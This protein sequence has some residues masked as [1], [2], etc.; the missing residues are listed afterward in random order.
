MSE[1]PC[2]RACIAPR[3][4]VFTEG[5]GR[6]CTEDCPGCLPRKAEYG[7]L[8][9]ACHKRLDQSLRDAPGQVAILL[10]DLAP[11]YARQLTAETMA[12]VGAHSMSAGDTWPSGLYAKASASPQEGEALRLAHLDLAQELADWISTLVER[13]CEDH[14]MTGPPRLLNGPESDPRR[15]G[16]PPW[17]FDVATACAW[18]RERDILHRVEMY[19]R[20]G[21]DFEEL[22]ELMGRAHAL[23]P[24]R[25]E[26]ARLPGISCPNCHHTS[27]VRYGGEED[28]ECQTPW[29]RS[30]FEWDRYAIWVRRITA[31]KS[32]A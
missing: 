24:W 32:G 27:L 17:R 29:C 11:A 16:H 12:R 18:L 20:V 6:A 26:M 19:L 2:I 15:C 25:E 7:H 30:V 9:H 14:G 5:E 1:S 8:C 3:R 22:R 23:R 13:L 4:H 10:A 31:E 28:V 21:D